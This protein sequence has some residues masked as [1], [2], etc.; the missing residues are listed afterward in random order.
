[1]GKSKEVLIEWDF[2][3]PLYNNRFLI[4]DSLKVFGIPFG[5]IALII[6]WSA[7]R[8]KS[9]GSTISMYG[10]QY[11]MIM[12][13]LLIALTM[14][15]LW[16]LY[17]N[18]FDTHFII[19]N[20]AI[21][22]ALNPGNRKK[23]RWISNLLI[24]LGIFANKPGTVGT[25][26]IAQSSESSEISWED[27]FA[28][29]YWDK[30][31]AISLRNSWRQIGVLYC[32]KEQYEKIK[33]I[34]AEQLN[35]KLEKRHTDM[36]SIIQERWWRVLMLLPLLV[37]VFFLTAIYEYQW[38]NKTVLFLISSWILLTILVPGWL[39][40]L[41]S[42]IGWIGLFIAWLGMVIPVL[43]QGAYHY[44]YIRIIFF[45]LGILLSAFTLYICYRRNKTT[46]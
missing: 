8:M 31:H 17:N 7:F 16:I 45:S 34:I 3:I 38:D 21:R 29:K 19:D 46:R 32:P 14:L 36:K 4:L 33:M 25:G 40:K 43:I 41:F 37:S 30:L 20:Y 18:R 13:G 27:I 35:P 6:G 9:N 23:A 11:A 5:V 26:L 1:V 42:I 12:V 22:M 39:R 2:A 44:D 10:F 15:L 24:I 28:V